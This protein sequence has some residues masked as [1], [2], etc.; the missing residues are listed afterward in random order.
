MS[1]SK[2]KIKEL[3][4]K[5]KEDQLLN[6]DE[7][8][9]VEATW[10]KGNISD[11]DVLGMLAKIGERLDSGIYQLDFKDDW[12]LL[13]EFITASEKTIKKAS[14]PQLYI[15]LLLMPLSVAGIMILAWY[16][17]F[18]VDITPSFA[19][20]LGVMLATMLAFTFFILRRHQQASIALE[21]LNEKKL[22][23][24]YLKIVVN[25]GKDKIDAE[26]LIKAGTAMF[27]GH[28]APVTLPLSPE[29]LAAAKK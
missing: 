5:L 3:I 12:N 6:Q 14:R 10:E 29:D 1:T 21:R 13:S 4:G 8:A 24:L 28:H 2:E 16:G 19:A 27:L 7:L 20:L 15:A 23:I 25:L 9:R 26:S 22:A 17:W 18:S 11:D